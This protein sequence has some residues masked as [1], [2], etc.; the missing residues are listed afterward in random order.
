LPLLPFSS[1]AVQEQTRQKAGEFA[2][3]EAYWVKRFYELAPVLD[4]PTD[5]PRAPRKTYRGTTLKGSLGPALY[6]DLKS[7]SARLGCTLYVTLLSGFQLLLHRLT[8]QQE[9]VVGISTAGQALFQN[10]SLVGHCVHFLPMLS[11]ITETETAKGHLAS[12]RNLLF[13]AFDHQEFTYGSLLHK[14]SIPRDSSRLPLIEAQFNLEKIGA[15]LEF[16]GLSA[17]IKA[18]P[19]RFVNTDMFLNMIETETDLEYDCDFNTDL[20]EEETI[21]RWMRSYANLLSN[22][23]RD[24]ATPVDEL[25]LLDRER[26]S[27]MVD[28]WNRT[29]VNFGTEFES[30]HRLIS[31]RAQTDPGRIAAE[32]GGVRWTA[33][34]LDR[35]ANRVA[36]RLVRNGLK[37]GELVGICVDRSLE[38]LGALLGVLK[39]GGV[40]VP[41]DP[42]HPRERLQIVLDDAGTKMLLVGRNFAATHAGLQTSATLTVLDDSVEQESQAPLDGLNSADELAY[43]IYTSGSTGKPKGVAVEHGALMNLLR[44]MEREPGLG[45]DDVL[46][47]VTT[48]SFDIAG[49]ELLLPLLTGARLVIANEEQAADGYQL[50]SLLR[51]S[52]ATVLQATPGTWMMMIEAGWSEDLPLKVLCGGEALPRALA[53]Q[54][55]ERSSQVWNVYGPTETTIW[56]SATAVAA[57]AGPLLIGPP[58]ANTQFYLLD[59]RLHPVPVGVRGELYIGGAG[60]ARGYWNRPDLTEERFLPN[61]FAPGRMYKTGD[62]GRWHLDATGKG[63]IELLGRTD[64]QVKV[65][66]YRIELGEIEAALSRHPAVR[67]SVVLAHTMRNGDTATTRLIA[68]VDAGTSAEHATALTADLLAM[69]AAALPEYMIP[70]AIFPLPQ[71]PRTPNGKIDR[72]NLPDADG[73]LK[74]GLLAVQR[75]Y[76]APATENQKRLVKIWGDVLMLDRVSITDSI[77]EL[78]ADS[79]L[80]F[81]MAS[82]SQKEGIPL[83]A[84]QI[85]RHRT[86]LALSSELENQKAMKPNTGKIAP[87]IAVAPRRSYREESRGRG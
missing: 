36:H 10:A 35:Y 48:L 64:F 45:E 46:V 31:R 73:L 39:A 74:T 85:F 5:R 77:F 62:L 6:S 16:N 8:G 72:K 17:T 20:F 37:A 51:T 68:Y 50:L 52:N 34:E 13:D 14:L 69:L 7:A 83:T 12:T 2:D 42:R 33:G 27:E 49:L 76:A 66:G 54:L 59:S 84:A 80:I 32:S 44:S 56:S 1:Y 21:R 22:V 71:L 81:R 40:Y 23:V 29:A 65:R 67:E 19:K 26:Q 86:I 70:A 9:V 58:I 53:N 38:M 57:G 24:A 82:R 87:R 28:G 75:S 79:L 43:V 25:E 41:L 47:A 4:L 3:N 63:Q 11:Q 55:L 30:V 15:R 18:N 61:S 78:G 60:L